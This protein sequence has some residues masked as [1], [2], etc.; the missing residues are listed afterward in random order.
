M[1]DSGKPATRPGWRYFHC[2]DCGQKWRET[3]RDRFSHSGDH[4]GCCGEWC[5]HECSSAVPAVEVDR[6][7]NLLSYE[8][9]VI[10]EGVGPVGGNHNGMV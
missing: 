3:S 9:V 2:N 1:A 7:G 8:V 4:C 6:M 10:V 5:A